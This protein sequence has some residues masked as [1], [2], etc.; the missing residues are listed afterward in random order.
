MVRIGE[1]GGAGRLDA[2]VLLLPL[3]ESHPRAC[4]EDTV[5]NEIRRS[6]VAAA[7]KDRSDLR[8]L[9]YGSRQVRAEHGV[10]MTPEGDS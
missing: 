10:A 3:A 9:K 2:K 4:P 6:Q 5:L 7:P 8:P 1:I